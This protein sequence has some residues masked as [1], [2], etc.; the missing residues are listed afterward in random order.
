MPGHSPR[1][2]RQ[3]AYPG[4]PRDRPARAR[5]NI[6]QFASP[7]C[8]QRPAC[9]HRLVIGHPGLGFAS[10]SAVVPVALSAMVTSSTAPIARMTSFLVTRRDPDG[11]QDVPPSKA[12]ESIQTADPI[13]FRPRPENWS[14]RAEKEPLRPACRT[15]YRN[16]TMHMDETPIASSRG[17]R[18]FPAT[19]SPPCKSRSRYPTRSR[20]P[21]TRRRRRR[22][23][24]W[25]AVR[26]GRRRGR[27]ADW[28]RSR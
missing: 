25:S 6:D 11:R 14:R 9:I 21:R 13:Q 2:P 23:G 20:S 10:S 3:R 19:S 5:Q 4:H 22:S 12:C 1:N 7:P 28:R 15:P 27:S 17:S 18:E 26:R 24:C 8:R 16:L